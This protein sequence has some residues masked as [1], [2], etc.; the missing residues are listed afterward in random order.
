MDDNKAIDELTAKDVEQ[1]KKEEEALIET[2][3][4]SYFDEF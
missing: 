1:R 4:P 3:F 2:T